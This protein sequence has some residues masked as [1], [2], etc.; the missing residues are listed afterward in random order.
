MLRY[1]GR[2]ILKKCFNCNVAEIGYDHSFGTHTFREIKRY[3]QGDNKPT[4]LFIC[5]A[6][7]KNRPYVLDYLR[8][9]QVITHIVNAILGIFNPPIVD[10]LQNWTGEWACPVCEYDKK[11]DTISTF[12]DENRVCKSCGS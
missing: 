1:K 4:T 6:C 7:E 11:I 2:L 12:W 10:D 9:D 3:Y 5:D 8:T